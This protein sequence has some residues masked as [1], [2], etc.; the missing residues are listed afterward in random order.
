MYFKE[1]RERLNLTQRELAENL[2]VAQNAIARYENN[3]VKPTSTVII[4]YINELN[5]NPNFLF[6]GMEPHLLSEVPK[7]NNDLVNLLNEISLVMAENELKDKLNKILIDKII[8]RFHNTSSSPLIKFLTVLG[9]QGSY[10]PLLFMYYIAQIIEKKI[11]NE[12]I[13][14]DNYKKFL[15]SVIEDFPVWRLF[16]NQPLFTEQI[17]KEFIEVIEYKLTENDCKLIVQNYKNT[18]ELLEEKMSPSVIRTHKNKF[19]L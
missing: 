15:S 6:L 17:K 10:R 16:F 13:K 9:I 19:K 1:F 4:K 12:N 18:L 11:I 3:K 2:E 14:I 8:D 5:A 7:L